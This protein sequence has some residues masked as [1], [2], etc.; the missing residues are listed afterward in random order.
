MTQIKSHIPKIRFKEFSW[1]WEEKKLKSSST[2]FSWWTPLTSK[3]EYYHWDI[4]FIKSWEIDKYKTQQFISEL[5]LKNSSAKMVNKWD[6]LYALYWATSW[7]VWI[8]KI[9]WAINQAVLCINTE[10]NTYFLYTILKSEKESILEKFLQWWQWNLSAEII[11]SLKLFF[12]QLPEQ[13]KIASFLSSVDEKIE[14]IGYNKNLNEYFLNNIWVPGTITL[15][16]RG[17]RSESTLYIIKEVNWDYNSDWDNDYSW[18]VW[19]YS[20][21][22]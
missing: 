2:F 13:Q 14:N 7:K 1:E 12:P 20:I 18:K 16:A 9:N 3:K 10:E 4:P 19:E 15:D 21:I 6:L 5:W 22:K 8:S 11:K 17:V